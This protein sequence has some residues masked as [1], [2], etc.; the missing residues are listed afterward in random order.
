MSTIYNRVRTVPDGGQITKPGIYRVPIRRYHDDPDLF[1]G[2]SV[3]STGLR[4]I[5]RT[6]PEI[7]WAHS[8]HNP[9]RIKSKSSEALRFGKAVHAFLLEHQLSEEEFIMCPFQNWHTNEGKPSKHEV[10]ERMEDEDGNPI[11]AADSTEQFETCLLY[12]SPSPRD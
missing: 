1:P 8:V 12:T 9:N 5:E 10:V 3:S 11:L 6:C 4:R 7:Y 2:H